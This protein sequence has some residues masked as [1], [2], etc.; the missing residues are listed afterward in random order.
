MTKSN[1]SIWMQESFNK[2]VTVQ[3][4]RIVYSR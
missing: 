1:S 2:V 4:H 3:W